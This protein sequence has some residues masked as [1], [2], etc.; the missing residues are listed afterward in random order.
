MSLRII[1]ADDHPVVRIGTRAV[2]ES[3]G[4][5]RV[6]GEADSAQALMALLGSQ[7]CDL[8]VTDYNMP[9]YSGI[10]LVYEALSIQPLLPIALA[11]G[12]ITAEI[13]QAAMAAGARALV[14]KPNDVEELCATVHRL[15]NER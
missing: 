8:L 3:S 6:V 15:L 10:D 2:I 4:V 12:Y 11:S 13:E 1:I 9:G 14:H 5:G 7:P